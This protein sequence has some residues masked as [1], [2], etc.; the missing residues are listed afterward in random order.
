M[1]GKRE[2]KKQELR[3]RLIEAARSLISEN[4]ISGL[5]ARD[6]AAEAGCALGGLYTVFKD[7]NAL[8]ME[9][10]SRTLR[11]LGEDVAQAIE[12]IDDP[13]EKIK[14]QARAYMRFAQAN[15]N[16]WE[17]LFEH[18]MPADTIVPDWHVAEQ[19]NLFDLLIRPLSQLQP[20]LDEE[21]LALHARTYFATVHGIVALNLEERFIGLPADKVE[22]E[23]DRFVGLLLEG[24]SVTVY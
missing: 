24:I 19:A 14:I 18:R 9:V 23:L 21:T 17:A 7:L 2:A 15:T 6:I 4:G 20:D 1:A 10:N 8:T 22:A 16:L 3:R 13:R 5:R 11:T 12:G